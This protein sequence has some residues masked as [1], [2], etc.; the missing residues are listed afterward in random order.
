VQ[1]DHSRYSWED[2][3]R[4]DRSRSYRVRR[5]LNAD[6]DELV[7]T[8]NLEPE[9]PRSVE[10]LWD[11]PRRRR[12]PIAPTPPTVDDSYRDRRREANR[13]EPETIVF[14]RVTSPSDSE[15]HSIP[16]NSRRPPSRRRG[17]GKTPMLTSNSFNALI[18]DLLI[19]ARLDP[20]GNEISTDEEETIERARTI[21]RRSNPQPFFS[22]FR[23]VVRTPNDG[24]TTSRDDTSTFEVQTSAQSDHTNAAQSFDTTTAKVEVSWSPKV[25]RERFLIGQRSRS[26]T[27]PSQTVLVQLITSILCRCLCTR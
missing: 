21:T 16:V 17:W 4:G 25:G 2:D 1:S 10:P 18:V 6:G 12:F 27:N 26:P 20:D 24:T 3:D 13:S 23:P 5:R 7:H 19:V 14:S 11:V 22:L 15:L 9:S 8:V